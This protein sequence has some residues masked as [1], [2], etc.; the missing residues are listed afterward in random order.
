MADEALPF[1]E[2]DEA[3]RI[4]IHVFQFL[5]PEIKTQAQGDVVLARMKKMLPVVFEKPPSD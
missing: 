5:L 1:D 4:A 3:G 2:P